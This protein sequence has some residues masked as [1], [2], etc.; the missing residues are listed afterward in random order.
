MGRLTG[1]NIL[2]TGGTSGIGMASARLFIE[3]GATVAVT[4]S[5]EETVDKA[6]EQ[7][8]KGV[9]GIVADVSDVRSIARMATG[10]KDSL[11]T[12][13]G[14]FLN[15]GVT[16]FTSLDQADEAEY[17]RIFNI[18][19]KG[20]YFSAQQCV[21]LMSDGGAIVITTSVRNQTGAAGSCLYGAS[22]AAQRSMARMLS[23]ELVG[24]GI[25]VNAL[26][27]GAIDTPIYG[28]LGWSEDQIEGMREKLKTVVPMGRVGRADEIAKA[29]LYL[30]SDDSSYVLGEELVVD[31]GFATL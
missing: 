13:H 11:G 5:R 17:D 25:R 28:K 18:N 6:L 9:V 8:G 27:P 19:V 10:V 1:K 2:I 3:E 22:K 31:G 4:G 16:G 29:A 24:K 23:A 14:L 20:T 21:P 15:A 12:L 26:C 7:L 30:I